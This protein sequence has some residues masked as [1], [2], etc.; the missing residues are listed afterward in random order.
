MGDF[1][2]TYILYILWALLF[3][4]RSGLNQE[5]YIL[6]KHEDVSIS[7]SKMTHTGYLMCMFT[8]YW[9][10]LEAEEDAI[11]RQKM[12]SAN[13]LHLT[14]VV[15]SV[16]VISVALYKFYNFNCF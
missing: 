10:S 5:I 8:F 11:I 3:S 2:Y 15:L 6:Q 16:V 4:Y 7:K 1:Q 9:R 13:R 14:F 12:V